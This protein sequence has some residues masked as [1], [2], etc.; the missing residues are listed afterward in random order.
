MSGNSLTNA[1]HLLIE[2][3]HYPSIAWLLE[4]ASE[5]LQNQQQLLVELEL[6]FN[7]R[8][9]T[10]DQHR[11]WALAIP[12]LE[13]AFVDL[14]NASRNEQTAKYFITSF[15]EALQNVAELEKPIPMVLCCPQCGEQHI[16]RAQPEK[17][18]NNPPHKTH[19]CEF[20]EHEWRPCDRPTVG[21]K[22]IKTF[23]MT[24]DPGGA[25]FTPYLHLKNRIKELEAECDLMESLK[26]KIRSD[27]EYAYSWHANISMAVQDTFKIVTAYETVSGETYRIP[28]D[29]ENLY[30]LS[31]EAASRFMM[32]AFEVE[33]SNDMLSKEGEEV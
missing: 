24:A 6:V 25:V 32:N 9:W 14:K 12:D 18:W 3:Q 4:E 31:N 26:Q 17:E 23:G 8:S 19:L 1:E 22:E 27:K 28:A 20:C 15:E 11:A 7:V 5:Q 21:V 30:K 33:T 10:E 29:F 13:K 16:D 2:A